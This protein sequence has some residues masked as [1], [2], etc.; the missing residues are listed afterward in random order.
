MYT[1][2]ENYILPS[3]CGERVSDEPYGKSEDSSRVV[4]CILWILKGIQGT[5]TR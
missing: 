1:I 3:C 5:I 4:P 2:F